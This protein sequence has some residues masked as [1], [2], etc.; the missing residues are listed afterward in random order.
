MLGVVAERKDPEFD[1]VRTAVMPPKTGQKQLL[2]AVVRVVGAVAK[3][4][5]FRLTAGVCR[6][7]SGSDNDIVVQDRTVSRRHADLTLTQE[8]VL[9]RD[10]ES[11]NGTHYLGH[12]VGTI[13]LGLGARVTV[14]GVTLAIDPDTEGL[15]D[16]LH[17][18]GTSYHGVLGA[19]SRMRKLFALLQRLESSV[20][21]VLIEGESGAGKEVVANAIH[22]AS[23]VSTGKLV[24]LNCGAIARELVASEL[25]GH[26]RGAFTGAVE[27]RKGAF[28]LADH[29]TLFLDEIGEL[30]L[31]VQP[32][33]LRAL[34]ASEI[35]PVGGDET[36][37]VKVRVIAATNRD[38]A[39][40]VAAGRFRQDLFY[41]LAVVRIAVPPLRGRPEDI[42]LLA[43]H[44]ATSAGLTTLPPA[45]VEELES[46]AWPGNA[47]ELR[48]ALQSYAA[49]GVLPPPGTALAAEAQLETEIDP[50][51]PY[52]E[53]KDR[54][55]EQFTRAYLKSLLRYA[56]GNQ[57]A[58]ARIGK[59]DRTYLGRLMA[60]Y[61]L[62]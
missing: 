12:R 13:V 42:E 10:L 61:G 2:G 57:A 14:G 30:P 41:R 60:K 28:E 58:A 34:D 56:N 40:E 49:L 25:F 8:G 17:Y 7:G 6:V 48:N 52:T 46:R 53:Q 3:P 4:L 36:R 11:R 5:E 45:I 59:L 32:S 33:L 9:L 54:F 20:A 29:G 23:P 44:F 22:E 26:K 27:T 19:S 38:L 35:K 16:E 1:D 62:R 55:V 39:A 21:T 43:R 18:E 24:A 50:T 31:D 47:R 37:Q 15:L 51:E